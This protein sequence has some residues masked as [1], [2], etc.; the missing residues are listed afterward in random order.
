[1]VQG[2]LKECY[3]FQKIFNPGK[4]NLSKLPT[5]LSQ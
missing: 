3:Q 4:M 1:M 2:S 5:E